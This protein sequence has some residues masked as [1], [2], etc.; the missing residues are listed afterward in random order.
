[1]AQ[2]GANNEP[3]MSD[4]EPTVNFSELMASYY[5][6]NLEG[7]QEKQNSNPGVRMY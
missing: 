5:Y 4:K 3:S 6:G 7:D 1:M 2:P